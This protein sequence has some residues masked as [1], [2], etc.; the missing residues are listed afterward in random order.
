VLGIVERI[1]GPVKEWSLTNVFS[2]VIATVMV[3]TVFPMLIKSFIELKREKDVHTMQNQV[4]KLEE[5]IK[6]LRSTIAISEANYLEVRYVDRGSNEKVVSD[7]W[8]N[9]RLNYRNYFV[10]GNIVARDIFF[11]ENDKSN[12][13]MREYFDNN[14]KVMTEK[15]SATGILLEKHHCLKNDPGN[16]RNYVRDLRS[17]LPP[18]AYAFY[19]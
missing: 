10:C 7:I 1:V 16:C 13:K 11:Y 18:A 3:S 14:A 19:R 8:E 2:I 9:G 12:G 5:R 17:P 6:K 15:F 4:L